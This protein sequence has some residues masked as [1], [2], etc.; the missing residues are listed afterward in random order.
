[1]A[2]NGSSAKFTVTLTVSSFFVLAYL[3]N[4]RARQ[5]H[6][7]T[8]ITA[9]SLPV[10]SCTGS[11]PRE[12]G[13]QDPASIYVSASN[14]LRA[15]RY[16]HNVADWSKAAR[17]TSRGLAFRAKPGSL[18]SGA[19]RAVC[20]RGAAR[21]CFANLFLYSFCCRSL[22]DLQHGCRHSHRGD[23][24]GDGEGR[25]G[26]EVPEVIPGFLRGVSEAAATGSY[27]CRPKRAWLDIALLISNYKDRVLL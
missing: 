16:F 26:R 13:Q 9:R 27:C 5:R 3:Y 20:Q 25:A 23:C 15:Q 11:V 18:L 7:H 22:T 6:A 10:Y 2:G 4:A 17:Q 12:N 1:M 14:W 19:K 8:E 21:V 24:R